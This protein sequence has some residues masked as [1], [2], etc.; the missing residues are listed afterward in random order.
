VQAAAQAAL[1]AAEVHAAN[2]AAGAHHSAPAVLAS[3]FAAFPGCWQVVLHLVL[4]PQELGQLGQQLQG[5]A[6]EQQLQQALQAAEQQVA[7]AWPQS[8]GLIGMQLGQQQQLEGVHVHSFAAAAGRA[9]MQDALIAAAAAEAGA[10]AGHAEMYVLDSLASLT[11]LEAAAAGI[12]LQPVVLPGNS[13]SSSG[14]SSSSS[15]DG[16]TAAELCIAQAALQLLQAAS[17][18]NLR[19]VV[20]A[21]HSNAP[22]AVEAAYVLLDQARELSNVNLGSAGE[23]F[24][25]LQL[26]LP[27]TFE[28]QVLSIV[29]L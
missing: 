26:Q 10:P 13:S 17:L 21:S 12:F 5:E 7:A 24:L 14:S 22:S 18:N 19:I 27:A 16:A 29:V 15:N 28:P 6:A 11:G 20:A 9:A 23:A 4:P 1:T 3:D 25:A 2:A 8:E